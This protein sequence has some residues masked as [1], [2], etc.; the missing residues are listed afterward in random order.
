VNL[1]TGK[2]V[3]ETPL[4]GTPEAS[5]AVNLGGPLI[6]AGGV[7]FMA[8][9]FRDS[10][11]RAFDVETGRELWSAPLPGPGRAAPMS[12]QLRRESKQYVVIAAT[13]PSGHGGTL[14]AFALP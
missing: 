1:D 13:A 11:L 14:L 5:G 7:V 3:W 2:R 12:Y 9:T 10:R 4:G 6:T 8:G